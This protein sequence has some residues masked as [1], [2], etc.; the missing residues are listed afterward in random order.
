MSAFRSEADSNGYGD[1]WSIV[2]LTRHGRLWRRCPPTSRPLARQTGGEIA[3]VRNLHY[4]SRRTRGTPRDF[5]LRVFQ[6]RKFHIA[7]IELTSNRSPDAKDPD[8]AALQALSDWIVEQGLVASEPAPLIEGLCQRLETL[9]LPLWR[10]H[11]SMATLHPTFSAFGGTWRRD[12]GFCSE[13]YERAGEQ[14]DRWQQSPL[15]AMIEGNLSRMRRRLEGPKARVDFP[16]LQ[17]FR[18]Q[19]ATDWLGQLVRFG[20]DRQPAG[21]PGMLLSWVSDRPGGF[22]E[23]N[24]GVIDRLVPRIALTCYRIAL[25]QVAENLL[26]AYVGADAGRRILAGQIERGAATRLSTVIFF[27]DLRGF[28]RLADETPG[29]AL[30][31]RLNDYLGDL[32]ET[33]EAHGGQ[34]LKFMGDGLLANFSLEE[35]DPTAVCDDA[36]AAAKAALASNA[37]LNQRGEAAGTPS[38]KLDIALHFG[39]L[40]YGN[41]G[42]SRRLDFTVIGPAVNEASRIESLCESLGQHL[43]ISESFARAHGRPLRSLGQHQLR[44]VAK[45]QELFALP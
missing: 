24:I 23:P 3:F 38:L 15:R 1:A 45:P 4:N 18:A 8:F 27:A 28:T 41:V 34:V 2:T 19:G 42:S 39:E 10:M 21:L 43:L 22:S 25:Q 12:Q 7:M 13:H 33:I 11:V 26:E 44:G 29:E 32:T 6:E 16:V 35:R 40:M 30:L 37:V 20:E 9:G 31:A 5:G 14:Q 36:I 17:E